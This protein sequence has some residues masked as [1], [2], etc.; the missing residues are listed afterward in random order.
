MIGTNPDV[1]LAGPRGPRDE[2]VLGER[3]LALVGRLHAELEDERQRLLAARR[4]RQSRLDAGE[5]FD[6][7]AATREVRERAWTVPEPPPDLR[8]RRVE[9]TGPPER[10]MVINALNSGARC[11][12]A[13]FEDATAPSWRNLVE[14][15]I[16]VLDAVERRIEFVAPDGRVYRL[17][18]NPAT[19][20]VRVRGLH[21][22]ERH[23]RVGGQTVAGCF[24]DAALFL[25][26]CAE[27][28]LKR[29][30][31]PYLYLPKLES[32]HE[33]RFWNEALRLCEDQLGLDR[34][35]VRVTVLIE[36]LPA[37]FEMDEILWELRERVLGLNAG[38][39]D[40]IFS[41]IK[42]LRAHSWAVLPDRSQVT[43]TVPFMRA[44]TE[45]LVRTCHRRRAQAIGGMAAA[46]PSRS[47]PAARERAL[48]AVAADKR[49]EA[50]DGF[51][52]TWVAHPDTVATAKAEF[53]RVL[54]DRPD[55]RDRLREDVAVEARDLLALDRTPGERTLQGLEGAFE[56]AL[57]YLATWLAGR[58]AVAI[59]GLME[60]A[61]TAEI[62]RAQVWQWL[63]HKAQLADGRT[64]APELAREAL[65]R[66]YERA[67]A[68]L[69]EVADWPALARL[70]EA[71]ELVR[72]LVFSDEFVEF[73]TLPAYERLRG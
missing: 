66:A 17:V 46:I 20:L 48:A 42:R 16:N 71:A 34:G 28:L 54:G 36:T 43:M 40:Y 62:C 10:K 19:L 38:R 58:G 7:P 5:L 63:R 56:V 30:S 47:D 31:G 70:G 53:D 61:A 51:D 13:D 59:H 52:G 18:E 8:D 14:G 6:F 68:G 4:E 29:G 73:L 25:A 9:I 11:F 3:A 45:L 27:P 1:E 2:E 72:R 21:L 50:A 64:V 39:W 24:V 26:N 49:R 67:R 12:M 55:Q 65:E 35:T 32:R 57:R 37:A 69:E 15:Q 22:P 44:Y 60:D 33:A 23:V 41:A